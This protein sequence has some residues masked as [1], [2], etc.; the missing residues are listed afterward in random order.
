[1]TPYAIVISTGVK[2]SLSI[3]TKFTAIPPKDRQN[4]NVK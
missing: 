4:P 3:I 1:M 2:A